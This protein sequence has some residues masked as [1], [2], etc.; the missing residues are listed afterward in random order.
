MY[1]KRDNVHALIDCDRRLTVR[2][3]AGNCAIAKTTVH[4]YLSHDLNMNQACTL[5]VPKILINVN[6]AK[7]VGY[8]QGSVLTKFKTSVA[9]L[10]SDSV[11]D[12]FV[13]GFMSFLY[14]IEL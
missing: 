1:I 5:W 6:L 9:R 11:K 2:E 7:R 4:K 12:C 3:I 13:Y 14:V 10:T 8:S